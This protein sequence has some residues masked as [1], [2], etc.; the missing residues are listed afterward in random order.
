V[1]WKPKHPDALWIALE[2]LAAGKHRV[3]AYN[4]LS[5]HIETP[6]ALKKTTRR[7]LRTFK[8]MGRKTIDALD[9]AGLI[10]RGELHERVAGVIA[11]AKSRLRWLDDQLAGRSL[12]LRS[13]ELPLDTNTAIFL[14]E[15]VALEAVLAQLQGDDA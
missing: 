4:G 9:S 11:W 6:E 3:R 15:R 8:N 12:E 14:T 5:R 13:L 2:P 7:Q 1:T 10:A